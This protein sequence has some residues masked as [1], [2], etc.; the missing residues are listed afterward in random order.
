MTLVEHTL[1]AIAALIAAVCLIIELVKWIRRRYHQRPR[2]TFDF[3][4]SSPAS[5][6]A[7]VEVIGEAVHDRDHTPYLFLYCQI[8][9]VGGAT[10]FVRNHEKERAINVEI[11][12]LRYR[13]S[14][15]IVTSYDTKTLI[16]QTPKELSDAL[17]LPERTDI[18]F[19]LEWCNCHGD[20]FQR[21]VTF[22]VLKRKGNK[23]SGGSDRVFLGNNYEVL[24]VIKKK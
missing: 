12:H 6:L 9:P 17:L 3:I 23:Y 19:Y 7:L 8:D 24:E 5:P 18:V 20:K 2:Q 21:R 10:L 16:F 14:A 4:P 11:V 13:L 22:P 15:S 1:G